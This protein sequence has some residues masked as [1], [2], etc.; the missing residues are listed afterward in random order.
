MCSFVA[1]GL[2]IER[3]EKVLEHSVH[4]S[5][6]LIYMIHITLKWFYVGI[7]VCKIIGN[8]AICST[9]C[10]IQLVTKKHLKLHIIGHLWQESRGDNWIPLKKVS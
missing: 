9:A 8:W 1:V 5:G 4:I 3:T 2:C 10:L 7:M 6:Y